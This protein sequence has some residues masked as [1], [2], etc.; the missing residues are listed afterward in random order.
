MAG[1]NEWSLPARIT[2]SDRRG[3]SATAAASDAAG[4][5]G[6]RR[7]PAVRRPVRGEP[8]PANAPERPNP[9]LFQGG[10]STAAIRNDDRCADWY[11]AT[12]MQLGLRHCVLDRIPRQRPGR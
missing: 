6:C 12:T 11:S 3:S 5:A 8:K 2:C 1:S 9:E 10:K 4:Q 7:R